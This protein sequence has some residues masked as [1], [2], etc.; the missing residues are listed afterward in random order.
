MHATFAGLGVLRKTGTRYL[1]CRK[2]GA[3]TSSPSSR[4]DPAS[5]IGWVA[6]VHGIDL[7]E[8]VAEVIVVELDA[9]ARHARAHETAEAA[10]E[11]IDFR[12]VLS[13][14]ADKGP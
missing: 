3:M 13:C 10:E 14:F 9:A 7:P 8:A 11:L 4:L 5:I 2:R 12:D 6:A 1:R